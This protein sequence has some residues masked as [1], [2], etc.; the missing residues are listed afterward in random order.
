M[1]QFVNFLTFDLLSASKAACRPSKAL[2][3]F[4]LVTWTKQ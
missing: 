4:F 2:V 1:L 3:K